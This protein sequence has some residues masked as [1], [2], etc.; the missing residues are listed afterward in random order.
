MY[1]ACPSQMNLSR[2]NYIVCDPLQTTPAVLGYFPFRNFIDHNPEEVLAM[3]M[4]VPS[5][6]P[7]ALTI[8]IQLLRIAAA[9]GDL[10]TVR[11]FLGRVLQD[12]HISDVANALISACWNGH[13]EVFILLSETPG[14]LDHLIQSGGNLLPHAAQGG[15]IE[16]LDRLLA[17]PEFSKKVADHGNNALRW[18]LY[19]KHYE[20]TQRL[21]AIESVLEALLDQRSNQLFEIAKKYPVI[22]D[23]VA[24]LVRVGDEN[25]ADALE[26]FLESEKLAM[27][28][29]LQNCF[30]PVTQQHRLKP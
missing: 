2:A 19:F 21:L 12:G 27:L 25:L 30:K 5:D 22:I 16:I 3:L 8:S 7:N 9:Q 24:P 11:Q 14:V 29:M 18:T 26:Q 23:M 17:I 28:E 4:N 13:Y 6:S 10:A 20:L 1:Q 15:N